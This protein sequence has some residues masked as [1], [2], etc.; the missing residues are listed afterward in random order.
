LN[1]EG[2]V[3]KGF[4]HPKRAGLF[5]KS[6]VIVCF[7]AGIHGEC[8]GFGG[9]PAPTATVVDDK[10]GRPIEGAVALAIWRKHSST[11]RA[12]WEG[13][14][15]VVVRIEEVVSDLNGN[16][17]IDGFW[18]RHLFKNNYPHLTIY[19]PGY[20]CWDQGNVYID[21]SNAPERTDF[22]KDHRTAR[23][24]KWPEGFSFVGHETFVYGV[25]FGDY[26]KAPKHLFREAF[27]YEIPFAVNE[28]NERDKKRKEMEGE[29][30]RREG[31]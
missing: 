10:T 19:K 2:T 9:D 17:F 1:E 29:N 21:E 15:D 14:T 6:V 18:N 5:V 24:R 30:K 27:H 23:M 7:V 25:T 13:G 22:D 12:W 16:I 4:F 8:L 28:N 26:N 11:A 3:K 20:V 31:K